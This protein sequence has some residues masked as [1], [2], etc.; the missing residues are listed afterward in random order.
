MAPRTPARHTF[1]YPRSR[2]PR[3]P[4]CPFDAIPGSPARGPVNVLELNLT[5]DGQ[6]Q[7]K[8]QAWQMS[9]DAQDTP[10]G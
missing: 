8:K 2:A 6:Y 7:V 4:A 9:E 10:G 5:L 1:Q 3:T